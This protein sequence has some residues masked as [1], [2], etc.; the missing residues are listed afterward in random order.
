MSAQ[1]AP[2]SPSLWWN[3]RGCSLATTSLSTW[4]PSGCSCD[5][6]HRQWAGRDSC[7]V[8][9]WEPEVQ[10]Q[11][12]RPGSIGGSQGIFPGSQLP[13]GVVAPT[14]VAAPHRIFAFHSTWSSPRVSGLGTQPCRV[15][16]TLRTT[17]T[18]AHDVCGALASTGGQVLRCRGLG[19]QPVHVGEGERS[20]F[21]L[22]PPERC[23]CVSGP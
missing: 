5:R 23:F 10:E 18:S 12:G 2:S 3:L 4:V 16:P 7:L 19:L 15:G 17:F 22:R 21:S 8:S 14:L 20:E 9:V 1:E 11:S 6:P 13:S